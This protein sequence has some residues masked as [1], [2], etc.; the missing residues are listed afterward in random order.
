MKNRN[1]RG[2]LSPVSDVRAKFLKHFA[3]VLRLLRPGHATA[4][5]EELAPAPQKPTRSG[6]D[7]D[8][9][10]KLKEERRQQKTKLKEERRQQLEFVIQRADEV[11]RSGDFTGAIAVYDAAPAEIQ[12]TSGLE[13]KR[14][15]LLRR[16]GQ[17]NA[18]YDSYMQILKAH[19]LRTKIWKKAGRVLM[20]L[21][22]EGSAPKFIEEMLS[23]L[24]ESAGTLLLA[25]SI[26][27]RARQPELADTLLEQAITP[28]VAPS[29]AAIL[30]AAR[31]YHKLGA[32]GRVVQLLNGRS[33]LWP[34]V[35]DQDARDLLNRVLSELQAAGKGASD[36]VRTTDRADA[37]ALQALFGAVGSTPCAR[38]GL[39]IVT[40]SL[41]PGG[42][43]RQT[44]ELVRHLRGAAVAYRKPIVLLPMVRSNLDPSFFASALEGLDVTV[45]SIFDAIIPVEAPADLAEKMALLPA[46]VSTRAAFLIDRL[47]VHQPEAVLAMSE[48]NGLAALIAASATGVPRVVLSAR[49]DPPR[50][51]GRHG[52]FLQPALQAALDCNGFSFVS[53]SRATARKFADW[54]E[55]PPDRIGFIYNG[56]DVD[57]F[58]AQRDPAATAAHRRQLGIPAGAHVVGSVFTART[59]KRPALWI[60]A[61][62]QI[63]QRDPRAVFVIIGG[64]HARHDAVGTLERH[65][66]NGRFH[67]PGVR[68]D[69]ATWLDLMDVVL[70]TSLSEGT[71]NVLLEAQALGRPIVATDVGGCAETFIPGVTGVLLAADPAPHEIA[72]AVLRVLADETM[73]AHARVK[74]PAFIRERFCPIR[75][76]SEFRD[77][78]LGARNVRSPA[79]FAPIA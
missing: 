68:N 14:A 28:A 44:I 1:E 16:S 31:V 12:K 45:E 55:Q 58:V 69:V 36:P 46:N 37:I 7:L 2:S 20:R 50:E 74:G 4:A 60:E 66:L 51:R 56:V 27:R 53:N 72:D 70:L 52:A 40:N 79:S 57:A 22:R 78:C 9:R 19:P 43:E 8:R 30:E 32:H 15:D 26:A 76:A 77:L 35:V 48:T 18:A 41:G 59:E 21:P 61:A 54:L 34:P 38:R 3:R 39:A 71:P 47:R 24:P 64:G 10:R 42:L 11:A 75:M 67:A 33:G 17:L 25:S 62:A 29:A 6:E 5:V 13:L 63:A 65:G 49:G 23:A 73:A